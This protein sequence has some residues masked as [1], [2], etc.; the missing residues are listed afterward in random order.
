MEKTPMTVAGAEKLRKDLEFLKTVERPRISDAIAEAREHGD[1]RENAE[2]DAARE[3]QGIC[4]ARIK[5]I[6]TQLA[7]AEIIDVTRMKKVPDSER[8][9]VFGATVKL[10]R[11]DTGEEVTYKIVGDYEA[12]VTKG[13]ISYKTPIAKALMGKFP[14]DDVVVDIPKGRMEFYIKEVSYI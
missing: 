8:K 3:E 12:D 6:E 5:N 10:E 13:Y 4:E 11:D 14:D 7:T 2:Y 1:L 9:V